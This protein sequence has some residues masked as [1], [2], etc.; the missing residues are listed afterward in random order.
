MKIYQLVLVLGVCLFA[1]SCK[2]SKDET[3]DTTDLFELPY[4]KASVENNKAFLEKEGRDF[5]KKIENVPD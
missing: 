1:F 5:I 3:T 2:K 4:N